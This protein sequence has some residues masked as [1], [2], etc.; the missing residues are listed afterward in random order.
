MKISITKQTNEQ[1]CGVCVVTTLVNYFHKTSFVK[2][3]EV[4]NKANLTASGLSVYD[5]EMLANQYDLEVDSYEVKWEEFKDLQYKRPIVC[6]IKKDHAF[7]HYV[8]IVKHSKYIIMFD[9]CYYK[10]IKVSYGDFQKVFCDVLVFVRLKKNFTKASKI[11]FQ[12]KTTL[13]SYDL[14]FVLLSIFA[15]LLSTGLSIL[16]SSFLNLLIDL[17]IV[18]QSTK[19]LLVISV[20][21]LFIYFLQINMSYLKQLY[22]KKQLRAHYFLLVNKV[23]TS[24]SF[25]HFSFS[26]KVD[27]VW[28]KR[29]DQCIFSISNFLVIDSNN[30]IAN[31]FI[32]IIYLCIVGSIH[33]W[34]IIYVT[35]FCIFEIVFVLIQ[36]RKKQK[37]FI[38]AARNENKNTKLYEKLSI[39]INYEFWQTKRDDLISQIKENYDNICKNFN[40]I[41][42]FNANLSLFQ[43]LFKSFIEILGMVISCFVIIE[44]QWLSL[45][46]LSFLLFSMQ[47]IKAILNDYSNYFL[48]KIEFDVFW[49]V[50]QNIIDVG[51][52]KKTKMNDQNFTN[53]KE[54]MFVSNN[55]KQI[56]K[57]NHVN[58]CENIKDCLANAKEIILDRREIINNKSSFFTN[59]IVIN[60]SLTFSTSYLKRNIV[61]SPKLFSQ[62]LHLLNINFNNVDCSW[63]SQYWINLLCLLL[64][65]NKIILLDQVDP[66]IKSH[67]CFSL[68]IKQLKTNN[69]VF[70]IERR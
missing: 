16:I 66:A 2:K 4:L 50:Y 59:L 56:L 49:D 44:Y 39:N 70:I 54:I 6:L 9:S 22:F 12:Q 17:A 68:L 55:N 64:E 38:E 60:S 52:V 13:F 8:I 41:S 3:S 46:Q 15:T 51:K 43:N 61:K 10:S 33:W 24:L 27:S 53:L 5:F 29:I 30:I 35:L 31:F 36:Y 69:A 58:I 19:N 57:I 25:K 28:L 37:N 21:F 63:S 67:T 48:N 18:K 45:G 65:K 32:F 11:N 34:A 20:F 62:F 47:I 23:L 7:A 14:R 1:E 40:D 42:I 26:K